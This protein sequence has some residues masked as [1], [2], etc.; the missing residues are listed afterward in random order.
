MLDAI[1]R[2]SIRNKLVIGIFSLA[3]IAWGSYSLKQLPIDAVPDITNNQVQIIT[4]APSQS[5][6]DIERLV[7]FPVEQ[8]VATIP[9]I[10]EVR[11]FSRFGLSVVT[12]VFKDE[13][14]VYHARQL[15]S[16]RL[17]EAMNQIPPGV[18]IPELAPVTTGL[19]EIYQYT[20]HAK[21]G[22]EDKYDAMELRTIQDWIVRRQL[23]GVEGVADVSSFGGYL[24][25]YEIALNPDK[26]KSM[27]VTI[28]DV[29]TALEKNN[30][31]TGGAYIDKKPYAW[32]IRSEGLIGSKEDIE[33]IVVK[34]LDN[35]TPVLIR[36]VAEV[37]YG[38]AIRYGALTYNDKGEAV[39]AI[40]MMLKGAN[41]SEVIDN[42]KERI[43]QIEKT[44]PEG[45]VIEPFL[46]RSRLVDN[47]IGTVTKNLMEG[48]LIVIFILVVFLGNFRAGLIVA[49]VIPLAMLFAIS[50]MN[51]F[52]VSGN[53]MS[54]GAIDFGL[55][56]DGA[57]IIVE[58]T[59]HHLQ[60]KNIGRKLTQN[61]M[62]DEV[63][64]SASKIRSS[65]AFG[66]IIILIVYLPILALVG[67]EGKMFKPMAQTVSF[68]ILGAFILSLTYVPMMSALLLRKKTEHKRNLSD[69]L[70]DFLH[71]IYSPFIHSS[72]KR[73]LGVI[74]TSLTL[75]ISSFIVFKQLGAEFLP[76]LDEG[77]FAVE[78]RVMTGSSLEE[79]I[80]AASKG[81]KILLERFPDEVKMV[82]GKIGS[83]EIPTD[84]MP[85]EAC[86]LMVILKDK[87][88]WTKTDNKDELAEL[89]TRELED[90]PGVTFGFQQP[91]QMRFNELMTGARQDV[92]VKIYGE[93]LDML[94]YYSN[95]VASLVSSID[96]AKDLYVEEVTG[97]RQILIKYKREEIARFGMNIE[98]INQ[99]VNT[100]FAG[101]SSGKVYE[102][103]K[104]FDMVVRLESEERTGI[105]DVQNLF[106]TTPGGKQI[107]L[108]QVADVDFDDKAP[109]Q[110]QRDDAKRRI[111]VG[112]NVRGRD[113]ESVVKELKAKVDK[114]IKFEPG[115]Y[116]TYGGTFQNLQDARARLMIAVP[117]A[118]LL[119]FILLYFT[120]ASIKQSL[121][122]YT[123]IPLAAIGGVYALWL[124]GMPFSISAGVGFIALF[125]VAVLNGIVLI[126]EFN[127][128]K[129]AGLN[130]VKERILR[131]TKNRLRPV[132]MTAA[133]ASLGFLPMA[134][135]HGSGAE[136]QKPLATVVIGGL[137]TATLLTLFVLPCI[138]QIV[139][140]GYKR[141]PKKMK[142]TTNLMLILLLCGGS[143][144]AQEVKTVSLDS[145]LNIA[146]S[147]NK[148]L[149]SVSMQTD[150]YQLQK[151]TSSELP[152]TDVSLTY[153]QYNSFYSSDNNITVSQIIPFPTVFGAKS[154]LAT[155]QIKGAELK[156]ASTKNELTYQIKQ[157]YYQL[158]FWKGYR[159]VL[160]QQD[161]MYGQMAKAA[162]L[163]YKT[164][165]GTLLEKTSDDARLSEVQNKL[166]QT[167]AEIQALN[168]HL[169]S[170]MGV[171]YAV[172]VEL[173]DSLARPF[174][175]ITDTAAVNANP[176]LAYIKQ[177][178]EIAEREKAVITNSALPEIKIGY[179]NQSLYGTPLN[180]ANTQ[181]AGAGNR[182]QGVQ[183][184]L[185]IPLWFAPDVNKSNAAQMQVDIN[186]MHYRSEQIMFQSYYDQAVQ[187]YLAAQ[188][189]LNYYQSIA[190][191]NTD[192]IEKQSQ[193]AYS[194]GD[195][196]YA[197]HLLNLQQVVSI[198][199][200]Y[201]NAVNDYN[202]TVIYIE[203]LTA[204]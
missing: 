143:A 82:V 34:N 204:R 147:N 74:F 58:A 193:T 30:Q 7:T 138:Y 23:L 131:G 40:V 191:P 76:S 187:H 28:S 81:S 84:P 63:F 132:I 127:R 188:N 62:D 45:V 25:Q 15:V 52:G 78:T 201:L 129:Q 92:V 9:G 116:P 150:Y 179:F 135:S 4:S 65:A 1:I 198:R 73:P 123:A 35:G 75:L 160:M 115:Y 107:P 21:P 178:I 80:D 50:L 33:N 195:I 177:Q 13:V 103:E 139:E 202:Q 12:V 124:R 53:L 19:G 119:I 170:L 47:A 26:L 164:G 165:D 48:A 91:I 174:N 196:G 167:N 172:S 77:D 146:C 180:D 130:D 83:G 29:F 41:S 79:T 151:K 93:D 161:S 3:L 162:D 95:Q 99:T 101:Q 94:T 111:T 85:I 71:R 17:N 24:K 125:G 159:T 145:A 117:V 136:V 197:E 137:I 69:R 20:L 184:G 148:N 149:Q 43:A 57:V 182:F 155:A 18:G 134:L 140:G 32:Y 72:L 39:G 128:L 166:K 22:Y 14:D 105:E 96:G 173:T 110:I 51:V 158:L 157:V 108:G 5:A 120:F 169:Q 89:M 171:T 59:L 185:I 6:Q 2:F 181:F 109:T 27:N 97:A 36:N 152:K 104:R 67:V 60:L 106:V 46:D 16:E 49:S 37:R 98:D 144:F 190:L 102:G 194:M 133:V 112:F 141:K 122:I 176:Q 70:M 88:E 56:V 156:T 38:H 44:L 200:G 189:N 90:V 168:I 61:E 66:E 186:E 11:S 203:Y 199:E 86:D 10:V 153:G 183:V 175:L 121:V 31:N 154:S 87:S 142:T 114:N 68:A 8:S 118:L 100:A 113:V 163:R 192:L 64:S 42:V 126:A 55:I 54:L